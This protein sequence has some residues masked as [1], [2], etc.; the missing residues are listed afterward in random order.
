[1]LRALIAGAV[2]VVVLAQV[3][4]TWSQVTVD[5][6]SAIVDFGAIG[7]LAV[8]LYAVCHAALWFL[9]GHPDGCEGMLYA[10][11]TDIIRR[12]RSRAV[13]APTE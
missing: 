11:T 4:G 5:R 3:P 13:R 8:A 7:F 9:S 6:M 2:T 10:L 12:N 1:M